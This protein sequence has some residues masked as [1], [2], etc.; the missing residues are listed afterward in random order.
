MLVSDDLMLRVV[1]KCD[2]GFLFL[3]VWVLVK[4]LL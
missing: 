2:L 1:C 3:W 4:V